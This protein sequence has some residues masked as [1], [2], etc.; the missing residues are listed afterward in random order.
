LK[1][2]NIMQ[3]NYMAVSRSTISDYKNISLRINP[4]TTSLARHLI[5]DHLISVNNRLENLSMADNKAIIEECLTGHLNF[6]EVGSYILECLFDSLNLLYSEDEKAKLFNEY[7]EKILT[8]M[9]FLN[10]HKK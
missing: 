5:Y 7:I 1:K 4:S 3:L 10:N 6:I 8:K 9:N 2:V